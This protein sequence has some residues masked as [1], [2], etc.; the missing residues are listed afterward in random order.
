MEKVPSTNRTQQEQSV[1]DTSKID[2]QLKKWRERLLDLT[3]SNP[4]LGLNR[5]R[6][7]KLLVKDADLFT[8]FNKVAV[9]NDTIKLPLYVIKKISLTPKFG[10]YAKI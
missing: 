6:V 3:K 9:E 7:S 8:L 10:Q 4:L 5:S 2:L 1:F